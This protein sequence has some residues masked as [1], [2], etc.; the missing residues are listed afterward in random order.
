MEGVGTR[1][2]GMGGVG[3]VGEEGRRR[4]GEKVG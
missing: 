2:G 3:S 1:F 4:V